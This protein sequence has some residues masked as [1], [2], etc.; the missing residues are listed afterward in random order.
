MKDNSFYRQSL[1]TIP[2]QMVSES[3]DNGLVFKVKF[4]RETKKAIKI[5]RVWLPK[6]QLRFLETSTG[7]VML[8]PSSLAWKKN[9]MGKPDSPSEFSRQP[10]SKI[11]DI[12]ELVLKG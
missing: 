11:R 3:D 2:V 10:F 4:E 7:V 1:I 9:L 5:N 6:S 12:T 8:I